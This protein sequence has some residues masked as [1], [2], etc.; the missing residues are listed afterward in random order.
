MNKVG[1]N[2]GDLALANVEALASG[3]QIGGCYWQITFYGSPT[4]YTC[5][6]YLSN[7]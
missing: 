7:Q 6:D 1:N 2:A 5:H 3:E 4:N